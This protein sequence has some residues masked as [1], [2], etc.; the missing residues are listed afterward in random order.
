MNGPGEVSG[1]LTIGIVGPHDLVERIMLSGTTAAGQPGAVGPGPVRRLVAAAYRDEHEAADMVARLGPAVDAC[2]FA[3]QVPYE[4][5][6]KAGRA[7]HSG[8]IRAAGRQRAICRA[9]PRQP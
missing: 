1:E 5:A 3:S 6:R 8:D 9:V 7:E 2:L 4:V